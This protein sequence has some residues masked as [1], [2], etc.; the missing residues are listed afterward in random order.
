M[1]IIKMKKN[2]LIKRFVRIPLT[3]AVLFFTI[4]STDFAF[5]PTYTQRIIMFAGAIHLLFLLLSRKVIL[6]KDYCLASVLF[7]FISYFVYSFINVI[8]QNVD[9]YSIVIATTLL[10]T[11]V[12]ISSFYVN[13]LLN[14]CQ[15]SF[16]SLLV[17]LTGVFL[18]QAIFIILFFV[19]SGFRSWVSAVLPLAN[20][21]EELA[22]RSRGF[23]HGGGALLGLLQGI[24]I[25]CSFYLLYFKT[26]KKLLYF[27]LISFSFIFISIILSGRTGFL[28]FPIL[29][30]VSMLFS[31]KYV[32]YF[33]K[34]V[35]LCVSFP[36][37]FALVFLLFYQFYLSVG[38]WE[39]KFGLDGLA[40]T[41]TW[42]FGE[43]IGVGAYEVESHRTIKRLLESHI[44]LPSDL[45]SSIFGNAGS[46]LTIN[47]YSDMGYIR[48]L[49]ESGLF[50][51]S[52]LYG[53]FLMLFYTIA[54]K[55]PEK[56]QK[57]MIWALACYLFIAE[58]K[59]PFFLKFSI[60][61]FCFILLFHSNGYWRRKR[62]H[63]I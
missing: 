52:L 7:L 4:F 21:A 35:W 41:L 42:T 54:K 36:L 1:Q 27:G 13:Y 49:N 25:W 15:V 39:T 34:W 48:I 20:G 3:F 32:Q 12:V 44:V 24:G 43:V 29:F 11:Q 28:I 56:K 59:E 46:W 14:Q 16:E 50:G 55:M 10:L 26:S 61:T 5:F 60:P 9:D 58:F 45:S 37:I 17:F 6:R 31:T 18:V 51:A 47:Q 62:I 40:N 23:T 63:I 22:F 38:A 57:M 33:K 2:I 8:I 53:G 19:N 30:F